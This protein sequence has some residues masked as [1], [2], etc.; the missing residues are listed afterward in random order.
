MLL[1][2]IEPG[3]ICTSRKTGEAGKI[4]KI[5]FYPTKYEVEFSDGRIEH[6]SS[7]D[8]EFEGIEQKQVSLKLPE[9]PEN[10]VGESWCEWVPFKSES[11]VEHHFSTS[12]EII[13]EMLTSLEMYNVWFHGI[14]RALPEVDSDRFVHKYS[15]SKLELKPGAYFKIRPMTIAP[16]F[17]CRIMT[18]EKEKEFGFTF[19]T[20]PFNVEFVQFSMNETKSGVWVRCNRKSEGLF[21]I[22]DQMNWQEKSKILQKL[23]QIVPKISNE[24][25]DESETSSVQSDMQFGGFAS[26]QDY[27][28]YAINMGM[29]G[30]M[31][32]VNAIPEKT[33]RG[34]AKAGMVKSKRTG[35]LPPLPEKVEGGSV[36]TQSS[37]GFDSLSKEDKVAYLV[38]KGLDGDMD[39]VNNCE[40]KI[41]RGKAKAMIVKINRGSVERPAM[42]NI[43]AQPAIDANTSGGFESLSKDDKVAFLVNKG[44]DGDMDAVNNCK[45][46]IIRGKAK[47]M[48]VKIKRGSGEKP[49]M[50]S[51]DSQPQAQS[52]VE[53]ET[54]EQK[55]ERLIAKGLE[56]D[57]DEINALDNRVMRGKIKA[58]IVKAK[59]SSK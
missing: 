18:Y 51:I 32:Y 56:G 14:Q 28:N 34:M 10:G 46:K 47:A 23:D 12:K 59:R 33:I 17:R 4:N 36:A 55:I 37:G 9:V 48:I 35:Q 45:D 27:I 24:D 57:M 2:R 38:N 49:A 11:Y 8:L 39:A 40:D 21:S 7:K 3:T 50:P 16:W 6:Y 13:W 30:D 22:L 20:N 29:N 5:F 58:A 1:N 15:F 54:D 42:P 41:I 25:S 53:S 43:D 44:L 19:Q 52:N 26:K 31:D